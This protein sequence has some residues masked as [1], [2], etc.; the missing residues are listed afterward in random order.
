MAVKT[1]ARNIVEVFKKGNKV[2]ICGNGGSST[3]A[4]HFANEFLGKYK[5]E[6]RSLPAIALN[7]PGLITAI[8]NDFGFKFVFSRPLSALAN[9]GD[10]L[11]TLSTSGKSSNVNYAI[12]VAKSKGVQ[13]LEWPRKGKDVGDIQNYQLKLMHDVVEEV[14]KEF[15]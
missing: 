4:S 12:Q 6:R 14:E 1:I 2:F 9:K 7:D 8:G 11:I 13:V 15:E 5:K 10:L 3:Q